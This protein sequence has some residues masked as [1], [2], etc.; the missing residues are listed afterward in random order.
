MTRWVAA[1][2]VWLWV[3]LWSG[4]ALAAD[5]VLVLR[6]GKRL[7]VRSEYRIVNEVAIF[8]TSDGQRISIALANIDIAAT[9]RVNGQGDGA[10]RAQARPPRAIGADEHTTPLVA[11]TPPP[12]PSRPVSTTAQKPVR[13]LTNADFGGTTRHAAAARPRQSAPV[14]NTAERTTGSTSPGSDLNLARANDEAYWRGRAQNLLTE[15]YTQQEIIRS[16][17][18]QAQS[19]QRR[20][21]QQGATFL[22]GWDGFGNRVL[23]PQEVMT[24]EK[25]ELISVNERIRDAQARLTGLYVQYTVLQE[26]ARRLGVPPGWLR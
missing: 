20:I 7:E 2:V 18:S 6:D 5:Y 24:A 8:T 22:L 23:L 26:E 25:R 11:A 19:L 16:L 4:V 3:A 1:T 17:S 10:F 12:T 21:D 13:T 15:I 9:E 14:P